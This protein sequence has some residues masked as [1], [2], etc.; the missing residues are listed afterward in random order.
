MA[1]SDKRIQQNLM[2]MAPTATMSIMGMITMTTAKATPMITPRRPNRIPPA[3]M[4]PA[5][6]HTIIRITPM[7]MTTTMTRQSKSQAYGPA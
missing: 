7:V 4:K 6:N 5:I 2:C 3:Q 1:P